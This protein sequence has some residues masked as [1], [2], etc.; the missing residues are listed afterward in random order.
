M[1]SADETI[2]L[3]GWGAGDATG[4]TLDHTPG[5]T[6][7]ALIFEDNTFTTNSSQANN[8]WMES[9]Y[10]A[11]SVWRYNTFNYFWIDFHGNTGIGTRWWEIYNNT[12]NG[13]SN[14]TCCS[15]NARDGSGIVYGNVRGSGS[16][17][18]FG[19]CAEVAGYPAKYQ[20]GRGTNQVLFP[21]YS[22]QNGIS[23]DVDGCAGLAVSGMVAANRDIYLSAGANCPAGGNCASGVGNGTTLPTTC[24]TNTAFWKTDA[25]GNWDTTHGGANDGAL[26]KCT[27]TNTWTQYWVPSTYPDP[28]QGG[29]APPTAPLNLRVIA[30]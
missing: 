21:A 5:S 22:F 26:F 20:I 30:P 24:T 11:I 13:G 6:Q 7:G 1:G 3:L 12:F 29:G 27:S 15:V 16:M 14:P 4:W 28:L 10:G 18:P 2:H 17:G 23:D 19:F 9:F 8:A 25:G